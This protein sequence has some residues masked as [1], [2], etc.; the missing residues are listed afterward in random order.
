[1]PRLWSQTIDAHRREVHT[2][3]LDTAAELVH[4]RG[5]TGITMSQIAEEAGI[6][7]ATLYKYFSDV[8]T[9]LLAWHERQVSAH[10]EHLREVRDRAEPTARLEAVLGAYAV[11][12]H[13]THGRH[14]G[15]LAS[16]LHRGDR[17]ASGERELR[18]MF[19]E[20]LEDAAT[21]GSVRRDIAVTELTEY[22]V[23]ALRAAG[24]LRSKGAVRRVVTLVMAGLAP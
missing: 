2:A 20:L 22:C 24:G 23:H 7:R 1:M 13:Q 10:L 17:V 18:T 19:R 9:I 21:Q 3:I 6:G 11:I 16:L 12:A 5:P 14:D 8:E 4:R 15:N